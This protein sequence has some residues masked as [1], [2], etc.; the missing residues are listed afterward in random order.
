MAAGDST[1]E[2]EGSGGLVSP[3]LPHWGPDSPTQNASES[4]G[5][6]GVAV[7]QGRGVECRNP[8]PVDH[9]SPFPP[10]LNPNPGEKQ[11]AKSRRGNGERQ[12]TRG[13][14]LEKLKPQSQAQPHAP[15]FPKELAK[16]Q[17]LAFLP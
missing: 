16:P 12:K 5:V 14:D 15:P 4:D 1:S 8:D 17:E 6:E 3:G 10:E 11:S 7:R 2:Y 13:R 9:R